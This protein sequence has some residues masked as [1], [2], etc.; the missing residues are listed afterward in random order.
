MLNITHL[1]H[2]KKPE[3]KQNPME[4]L[5]SLKGYLQLNKIAKALYLTLL[6]AVLST[7]SFGYGIDQTSFTID[8]CTGY[9]T[10]IYAVQNIGS[11]DDDWL[12][13]GN[14][15][16]KDVN[17]N[18]VLFH[19][20]TNNCS[21]N[22]CSG[23]GSAGA[24]NYFSGGVTRFNVSSR[25]DVYLNRV[26]LYNRPSD[27]K[28]P[29]EFRFDYS[30]ENHQQTTPDQ[31]DNSPSHYSSPIYQQTIEKPDNLTASNNVC[32][33]V[34]LEWENPFQTWE[35][36]NSCTN[37]TY[38]NLI[39][40]NNVLIA[41]L[42]G[43]STSFTDYTVAVNTTYDYKV[44]AANVKTFFSI[45]SLYSSIANGGSKPSPPA[46]NNFVATD[47][48]CN[49]SIEL[50]WDFNYTS[51]KDFLIKRSLA[52]NG[53]YTTI[54]TVSA[55]DRYYLDNTNVT[56]GVQYYYAITSRNTCDYES[57]IIKTNGISPVDPA[58]ATNL[59]L[60]ADVINNQF[61]LSWTDNAT[62]EVKYQVERRDDQSNSVTFDLNAN[63]T[64][65]IDDNVSACKAYRYYVKVFSGCVP[66]GLASVPTA[67]AS[68]PVP[69][70]NTTFNSAK[71][72]TCSK[73]YFGN[74]VELSWSN[75]N[76]INID[77]FKVYR[78]QL[79]TTL[80][81]VLIATLP[82]SSALYIDNTG[83]ARVFYRYTI[84]G[85]KNCLNVESLTNISSDIGFRDPT[86]L[87][88]GH[89]EYAGGIAV[90]GAKVFVQQNG[91]SSG[92]S[93]SFSGG[94][95]TVSDN[96]RLEPGAQMRM[97][98]WLKPDGNNASFVDKANAFSFIKS[99]TNYQ[100]QVFIG[101]TAK[102]ITTTAVTSNQW[103]HVAM[104]YDGTA[105]KLF[106]NG[107]LSATVAASG[108]VTDNSS[109]LVFG[110]ALSAF[111][112]DEFR[113][114][115]QA[116]SDSVI[117]AEAGR[118]LNGNETGFKC[119]LHFDEGVDYYAYDP[120]KVGNVFNANH[121][122]MTGSVAW[123]TDKPTSSQLGYF[124][125]T[126]ALGNYYVSGI[127]YTGI[128]ENFSLV[129]SFQTHSFAPN[130]RSVYI[131]DASYIYNN[132]DFIDNSS[133][134]VS[135]RLFYKN[136][137]CPVPGANLKIDGSVVILNGLPVVTDAAG[138]FSITVPIGNHFITVEKTSHDMEDGRYPP[139]GTH[140]F[141]ASV[142][143]I[144]FV[145]STTRTLVG[146][147]VGG[148]VE[149]DKAP[150]MGRSVNNLGSARIK[151]VSP[152][153]GIPCFS[154]VV[155]TNSTTGEYSANIPPLQYRIDSAYVVTNSVVINKNNLTNANKVIDLTQVGARTTEVD[156]LL[157]N[158]GGIVSIDSV[159]FHRRLDMT[160]RIAPSI[161]V[162]R[163]DGSTFIGEDSLSFGSTRYS[164]KP[165]GAGWGDFGFPVFMQGKTYK[166]KIHGAEIYTN[167]DNG[168]KD[169]VRLSG[170]V[171][172]TNNLVDG[173]DPNP[174][175]PM[176]N[177]V[178]IY[179]FVC[180]EPNN[181]TNALFPALDY[182]KDIQMVLVP[183]GAASVVWR[184]NAVPN[185]D[186]HAYVYGQK[187]TGTGV[188]TQGPEK[189]D[190]ILRDP[191][192]SGSSSK[193][194]TGTTVSNV[195][196]YSRG[197]S[198]ESETTVSVL[199]GKRALTG[200]LAYY[201]AIE[202][203]N[204]A[205]LGFSNTYAK[206]KDNTY[207]E[208]MTTYNT[209]STRDDANHVGAPADI[210][211]GRAKNWLV[212]PTNN[213]ELRTS[214]ACAVSGACFGN[215][216]NG[217][218]LA[219]TVG[220]AIAPNGVRTRFSYTQEEIETI[221][222][223][224]LE[225]IRTS[226]LVN[227]TSKY[228]THLA[229]NHP[230]FGINNDDPLLT[231][232]STTTP[233]IYD[234][235]DTTGTSYTVRWSISKDLTKNTIDSVRVLNTQI[236]LW[237]R[238]LAQNEREKYMCKNN[239]TGASLIDN[240]TLGSAVVTSAYSVNMD[241]TTTETYE[242]ALG[243]NAKATLGAAI[244]GIG[245]KADISLSVFETKGDATS[246]GVTTSN[247]FDYTLTDGDPGDI[248]SID[249]YKSPEG[250]GNV[251]ITRGGQTM[252]P[253][254]DA[255]N[256][257]YYN[258]ASPNAEIG[259]H[260]YNAAG[261]YVLAN[262]T[263][264]REMP[265][266]VIT[267][268]IQYN[269]PSAQAASY[270]L[271]LSNQSPLT[272]NNDL[273]LTIRV[274]SQSNPNGA[275]LKIDGNDANTTVNIPSGGSVIKTLTI[276]RG[277]IEIEYDS[278]MVIFSSVCSQDIAD[279]AYVTVHF[280]PTCTDLSLINPSNNWIL[281]NGNN[282]VADI[283]VSNYNYN[284]GTAS[285]ITGTTTT[286]LGLNKIGIEFRPLNSNVWTEFNSFYKY[287]ASALQ[288]T[289]PNNQIYSDYKWNISTVPDGNYE[290]RALSYCLNKDAS[291]STVSSPIFAGIMD[292]INPSPFG[293]PTPGDGILDPNDD[294]SIQFNEP[295]DISSLSALNFDIRGV[296]NGEAI[297][298]SESLNFNGISG[299]A[300]VSG[301]VSIQKRD[302]TIEFW[303]KL[304]ATGSDQVAI[305]QGG[306][307]VQNMTIGFD[308]SDRFRFTL[309]TQTV[310]SASA[311]SLPGDWHHYAVVYDYTGT[312]ASVYIDGALAGTNS[313]FTID[314]T[315]SGK[316]VFGKA[317]PANNR[318][319][320]G[321][322]H[323]VRLWNRARSL[324]DIVITMNKVLSRNQSGLVYNWKMDEADGVI[325]ADHIRSRNAS[326][327]GAT[328]EVNPNGNAAQFDGSDDN[329]QISSGNI[330][331]NK[332]MDF[333]LEFWFNS[334]QSGAATLFS[335]GKGDG[336][337]ADSTD[338]W[339]IQKDASGN[340]HV[341]HNG[342]DFVA[343]TTNY[344]N[345]TWHHF[346]LV[347][348]R[349]VNLSSYIDGNLQNSV[350][351]APFKNLSGSY[352]YLGARGYF[353]S[354]VINY[355]NFYNGKLDEFRLWNISR[356][357]EQI[358]R[359]K[360]NR[361][362]GD[363]FGLQAFVPFESYAMVLG[364]PSLTA[365]FNDQSVN[366]LTVNA[367][368]GVQSISQT[369]TIKLPRPVQ[370]VNYTW[371]LNSDKIILT[372][373]TAPELIENVTLDIT[374][375]N[376]Y[377]M[378]A[379]RMQ[380]PKTWIAYINKNQVKWQ[381]DHYDFQKTVDSTITFVA[382]IVNT[383]GALKSFTIAGLP[384]WMTASSNSGTIAPNSVQSITFTIPAGGSIGDFNT[385][386][387]VTTDFNYAEVL[388]INLKVRGIV[389][390]WSVNPSD[391]QYSMS[392]F[393]QMKIDHVIATNPENKI[394]AF[395]NG[396]ICGVA[397]LQYVPAY[398][399]YEVFLS[400]Y[401]NTITGDSIRFN[402]YD[403]ASGLTFV[404]VTPL[405]M[406]V[407]ND[408]V[409]TITSPITFTANTEILRKIPL[410]A[411]WTWIS[412][413]LESAKLR[414]SN[415][416]MANLQSST[417][418]I[419]TGTSDY[420][421]FDASS[422]WLGNITQGAGFFNNQS[423]KMKTANADT[424]IHIGSRINPDSALATINVVP[425]WN[426]IGYVS[427]KNVLVNE[428]L[429]NYNAVTGDL[430]KSQYQFAYYDNSIGW[431]GSLTHMKPAMGYMLQSG[432]IST[433]H[434]PLSTFVGRPVSESQ[435]IE[436]QVF[437][438]TPEV[439]ANTMSAIL[440]GNIC[441]EALDQNN[442]VIGAFDATN[443][444]RGYS[445]PV[446]NAATGKYNFYL[447]LYS[448]TEGESLN[449]NYFNVT[450]GSVLPTHEVLT[451]TSNALKGKPTAPVL[452]NVADSLACR[453]SDITGISEV[454]SASGNIGVY[455]NPFTD[456]LTVSFNTSVSVKVEVLDVLGKVVYV[457]SI[458]NKQ[459]HTIS[460]GSGNPMSAGM[461]LLRISGDVNK[462]V[463]VIKTK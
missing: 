371:S 307:P 207:T 405:V 15:F 81:S 159:K 25:P 454:S 279:T 348:Q 463:K 280:I 35:V 182:T 7:K 89:I 87:V 258:P 286:I 406:F 74:R 396:V 419:I 424:L 458:K 183:G 318:F 382:P 42:P 328:W 135:G 208:T 145:D 11:S 337:G 131:G 315:G 292:R 41:T 309:G 441:A 295:I 331:L 150:G 448:N 20:Y 213:I 272:V 148:L 425:G 202:V 187:I 255:V 329:L 388:Q 16:Y 262:A 327:V 71:K 149:T 218:Q 122:V 244:G 455:P 13:A 296:L 365:T 306:D 95:L 239:A 322:L 353:A 53:V 330:T 243:S 412:L 303:A 172:V 268:A 142:S 14:L 58:V 195:S 160:Y 94:L 126:D 3:L 440:T 403:A 24:I 432:G 234:L 130:S 220:Y 23:G 169:T 196:S 359:D 429:G 17:N 210:F 339:N 143:N 273:N 123:S 216:V 21:S 101:G 442:L 326:V 269:I 357:A 93:L 256:L 118:I 341:Y 418:D 175:A 181:A 259:S 177:G 221:V 453:V 389:P 6:L 299:Y 68:L 144:N 26:V 265:N 31:T 1:W 139:I 197:V 267:P 121:G 319:L 383:G 384:L 167:S 103:N 124:G 194:G 2:S 151:L 102:T 46:P 84:V 105:L 288:D 63:A 285:Y 459:E 146:R 8:K 115:G 64:S 186:Y 200:A 325:S 180:G 119:N 231:V 33:Q 392:I 191:P 193:W 79:G 400:V 336:V 377:D 229:A 356:R 427:N 77:L 12:T 413:P 293:T 373:T 170:N 428:A 164:I 398:D 435:I 39:Y 168:N 80:D 314:Y 73:G 402:I 212:G 378:H 236:A 204:T 179:T 34:D 321:N 108:D 185:S 18:W 379:N 62:N 254:E 112:L 323:D 48:L 238:A 61:L 312:D 134:P 86:G 253:Y 276:E 30:W 242:L 421:Q 264:Q 40:K 45:Y 69:N 223:P 57:G 407:E 4:K 224:T 310:T 355:D 203:D 217:Y 343:T 417:G 372:T 457:T 91:Q 283:Q 431:T 198:Q 277:P 43:G 96:A 250:T 75:N 83:D 360:Q 284:Y 85:A 82:S 415:L 387:T 78:K 401:S 301:G 420:D 308:N 404:N 128:G 228:T 380:S 260:S 110:N 317:I 368:N 188:S 137:S 136:T 349:G 423:Y 19:S 446:F 174:V 230:L 120:S 332:E 386:L 449:L 346:S 154:I 211:I 138:L 461:Y 205:G 351:A 278:I 362:L 29:Y 67:T 364:T 49:S 38:Q 316:L 289:I 390:S 28:Y 358:K 162:T 281:N 416:L 37:Q 344:F 395:I 350:Q 354:N 275:V 55:N 147:V 59:V 340:I 385:D 433:F 127:R 414:T 113:L 249:V 361:M 215:V 456:N 426:W 246:N 274:A 439:Y 189:V 60:T 445:S 399:R 443:S 381:D 178:A 447:T 450:D 248:M 338:S 452:A 430:I 294:I 140:N 282:N 9:I 54:A 176:T 252:C 132:Q 363:E 98:F 133:F 99:G 92:N 36:T 369:P 376:A 76:A 158:L 320:N 27:I 22:S 129:P 232:R 184:P 305:S 226:F 163:L 270:Q 116:A 366:S 409:G 109:N 462:Q 370:S 411:G 125:V 367:Q 263:V 333:T 397:D 47:N 72:L 156:T 391:F 347:L 70:L 335:N 233:A 298:H 438:F 241:N 271:L 297:R 190:F 90:S 51:P 152:I 451:F 261:Y 88:S 117:A 192:G 166:A 111:L 141:Q 173:A 65:Y 247:T 352:M 161:N 240:F 375:K 97:E 52:L 50:T 114:I 165:V 304:N 302:F 206:T 460:L 5:L 227:N 222:I 10:I 209:V 287:P 436:Q 225:S 157:D 345:G 199:L 257:H 107:V 410:N 251:F 324:S 290:L 311:V 219:K 434:Y 394:A 56:R 444:L 245:F 313:N 201:E 422:G 237:K 153:A 266:I 374:V 342:L 408:V 106:V 393:G 100:A 104:V 44:R 66:S 214:A 291:F 32:G 300:E 155:Q 437:P 171:F 235:S 334:T